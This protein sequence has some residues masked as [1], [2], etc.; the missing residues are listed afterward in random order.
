MK[1]SAI[2]SLLAANAFFFSFLPQNIYATENT[3]K[4]KPR[5][6]LGYADITYFPESSFTL[7]SYSADKNGNPIRPVPD[8]VNIETA[9]ENNSDNSFEKMTRSYFLNLSDKAGHTAASLS[10]KVDIFHDFDEKE[11]QFMDIHS[12]LL[13]SY[14]DGLYS[15]TEKRE[16]SSSVYIYSGDSMVGQLRFHI[17]HLEDEPTE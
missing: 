10:S 5:V 7:I 8:I 15:V 17:K 6:Q 16:N 2:V 3:E 1:K 9:A 12:E 11:Y 14:I 4:E 13:D